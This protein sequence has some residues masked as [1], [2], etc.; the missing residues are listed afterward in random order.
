VL[1]GRGNVLRHVGT[2]NAATHSDGDD[3]APKAAITNVAGFN[4]VA[5]DLTGEPPVPWYRA[6]GWNRGPNS[7]A[8]LLPGRYAVRLTVDEREFRQSITVEPDP[9]T[10]RSAAEL[11]AHVAYQTQLY[12]AFSRIDVA[13]NALDNIQLELPARI[14][15]LEKR[16][17]AQALRSSAQAALAA[18]NA[19]AAT[20]SSHPQNGQDN[21]FLRDLLRERLQSLI[22]STTPSSPTA[23]QTRAANEV[24]G[25]IDTALA[26]HERF[27]SAQV[28][29]LQTALRVAN[30]PPLDLDARPALPPPGVRH[31]EYGSRDQ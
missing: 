16:P 12:A 10:P 26:A 5:W 2:Q 8:A 18:A 7:G 22:N 25:E 17:G 30:L 4:R 21:D 24:F 14:G 6:P 11:A 3:D 31:D 15:E 27:M 28:A 9:R 13:L 19:D 29:P 1:D 23:E 20:L